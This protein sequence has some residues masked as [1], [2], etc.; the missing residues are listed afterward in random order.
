MNP[1]M[2]LTVSFA[3][4]I[5]LWIPAMSSR[6]QTAEGTPPSRIRAGLALVAQPDEPASVPSWASRLQQAL[7][8]PEAAAQTELTDLLEAWAAKD[9]LAALT[10]ALDRLQPEIRGP[11]IPGILAQWSWHD[12]PG[13]REWYART[14]ED[15]AWKVDPVTRWCREECLIKSLA[16]RDP[17][18]GAEFW[19]R[20]FGKSSVRIETTKE[21]VRVDATPAIVKAVRSGSDCLRVMEIFAESRR[22]NMSEQIGDFI[23]IAERWEMLEPEVA[24]QW[25]KEHSITELTQPPRPR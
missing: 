19:T 18:M 14:K 22:T 2:T 3:A 21:I 7:E 10:W 9:G 1:R 4:G 8:L 6:W 23:L 25:Q 13:V 17:A 24:V 11:I 20:D 16:T 5:A 12:P 15:P